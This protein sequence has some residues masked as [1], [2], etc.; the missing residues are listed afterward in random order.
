M[1][2]YVLVL[3][4]VLTRVLPHPGWMNFTAVGGALL[5]FGARRSWREMLIPL[6]VLMATD[7]YLTT[8]V[9]H[10]PFHFQGYVTTWA[11][12]GM[13]MALGLILLK[14]KTNFVRVAVGVILGPTSFFVVS[15]YAVWASGIV[16]YPHTLSGLMACYVA[17][18]P[19]YRN[20]L[21]STAM[22]AGL[23]FGVPALVRRFSAAPVAAAVP[24]GT[25]D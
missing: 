2:A 13:A 1:F 21:L 11:W 7:Y 25:S 4:A 3:L 19:F 17:A 18:I 9:Y 24:A 16:L 20:D 15:N 22:V 23:A 6:T 14:A 8:Y 12:Y 10:Y 5:Y